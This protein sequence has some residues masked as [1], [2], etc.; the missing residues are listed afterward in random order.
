MQWMPSQKQ[1]SP[2]DEKF[3]VLYANSM[4]SFKC[5]YFNQDILHE[6]GPFAIKDKK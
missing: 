3:K 2:E 1:Q 6:A 4:I 5:V